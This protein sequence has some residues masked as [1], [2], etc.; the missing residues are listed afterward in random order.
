MIEKN[1]KDVKFSLDNLSLAQYCSTPLNNTEYSLC[2]ISNHNGELKQGHYTAY[3]KKDN[4]WSIFDDSYVHSQLPTS[5]EAYILFYK[6]KISTRNVIQI[7]E[8]V[9]NFNDNSESRNQDPKVQS[10]MNTNTANDTSMDSSNY[11]D[12]SFMMEQFDNQDFDMNDKESLSQTHVIDNDEHVETTSMNKSSE[13]STGWL[14]NYLDDQKQ[15]MLQKQKPKQS[16]QDINSISNSVIGKK[17][18]KNK[19]QITLERKKRIE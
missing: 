15:R 17:I 14:A 7:E 8:D 11:I 3:C 6:R 13:N 5:S 16:R 10:G 18:R 9:I 12:T 19:K 2:A 4:T 1:T